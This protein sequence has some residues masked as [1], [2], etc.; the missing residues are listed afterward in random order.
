MAVEAQR[1]ERGEGGNAEADHDGKPNKIGQDAEDAEPGEAQE[2]D[3]DQKQGED[4]RPAAFDDH[5]RTDCKARP[6]QPGRQTEVSSCRIGFRHRP[7]QLPRC[8][9]ADAA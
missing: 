2:E 7:F 8:D 1:I 9:A 5:R 3:S 6:R 4:E